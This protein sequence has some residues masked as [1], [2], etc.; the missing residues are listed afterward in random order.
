[1]NT[2]SLPKI[3]MNIIWLNINISIHY[4]DLGHNKVN[5]MYNNIEWSAPLW[6][7]VYASGREGARI[8]GS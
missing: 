3:G 4:N 2:L 7:M 5:N 6:A 8:A 1:M